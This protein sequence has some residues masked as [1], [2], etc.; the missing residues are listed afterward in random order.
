MI[1]IFNFQF[2]SFTKSYKNVFAKLT[3]MLYFIGI[4]YFY[5]IGSALKEVCVDVILHA[6]IVYH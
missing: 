6:S 5:H 4:K 3:D 2:R 1:C